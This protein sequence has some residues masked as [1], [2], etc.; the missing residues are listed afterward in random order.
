M[1]ERISRRK[2]VF[3]GIAALGGLAVAA[4]LGCESKDG[5]VQTTPTPPKTPVATETI[6]SPTSVPTEAPT[7]APTPE[8]TE[9]PATIEEIRV[10]FDAAY[11]KLDN[12][13]LAGLPANYTRAYIEERLAYCNGELRIQDIPLDHPNYNYALI[14]GCISI[15]QEVVGIPGHE[16]IPEF[17]IAIEKLGIF[18]INRV[19]ELYKSDGLLKE[20]NGQVVPLS[21]NEFAQYRSE[22]SAYFPK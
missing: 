9:T 6:T 8:P 3:G 14:D 2:V 15:P 12:A 18:T 13:T 4:T 5:K 10:A 17:S 16:D 21:E 11:A 20:E 7:V 22:V 1:S 19:D